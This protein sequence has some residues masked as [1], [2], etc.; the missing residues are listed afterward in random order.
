MSSGQL[1]LNRHK[2]EI[3]RLYELGKNTIDRNIIFLPPHFMDDL[4]GK[5]HI[6]VSQKLTTVHNL[7]KN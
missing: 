5:I 1:L 2:H 6:F 4:I 3:Y 7:G